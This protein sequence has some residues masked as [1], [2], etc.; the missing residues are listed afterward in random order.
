MAPILGCVFVSRRPVSI[1]VGF[2]ACGVLVV[3]GLVVPKFVLV[4]LIAFVAKMDEFL[5]SRA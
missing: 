5:A 2:A 1:I 4:L 3:F